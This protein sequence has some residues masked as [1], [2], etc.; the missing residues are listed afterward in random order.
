MFPVNLK[1]RWQQA[2]TFDLND[3]L[4]DWLLDTGS[5][6]A[7]LKKHSR[8]F[9]VKLLGQTIE[10]CHP[11][12]ACQ[13][14]QA[15]EQV[16]VREVVLLCDEI[17]QVFARSLIPLRSLTGKAS[18]LANLGEQSLG[19]VLFNDPK[20]QRKAIEVAAFTQ[21]STVF[22]LARQY[23][24]QG[25]NT[26]WGRRSVFMLDDKPLMVAEV[27]LPNAIAY[28]KERVCE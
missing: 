27:F 19:Q 13:D 28:H 22:E 18:E 4:L 10:A 24:L 20:L 3:H 21:E 1:A 5:L 8:Q 9:R 23:Q 26:L 15:N 17:P 11:D 7:R 14:I 2:E 12:E 16:L 25:E 6:T